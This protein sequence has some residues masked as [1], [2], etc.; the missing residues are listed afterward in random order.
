MDLAVAIIGNGDI[1]ETN[2]DALLDDFLPADALV[3]IPSYIQSPGLKK[4]L[5]WL[6]DNN[7]PY[8][9]IKKDLVISRLESTYESDNVKETS[10]IVV[11][12]EGLEEDLE[13]FHKYGVPVYDLTRG[14]FAV[15]PPDGSVSDSEPLTQA[16]VGEA[17]VDTSLSLEG[18]VELHTETLDMILDRIERLEKMVGVVAVN[19]SGFTPA[20]DT[21]EEVLMEMLVQQSTKGKT[22]YYRNE[23]GKLRKA[24]RSKARPGETEVFLTEEE[25]SA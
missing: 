1:E 23:S 10:V 25:A 21:M 16:P 24:G 12:T 3:I 9:R 8:E 5:T 4:V 18:I 13:Y 11:G 6:V 22:K 7:Q 19:E 14:L 17:R 15:E 20:P 2:L